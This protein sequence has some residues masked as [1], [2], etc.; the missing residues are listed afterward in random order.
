M[1][2]ELI[3]LLGTL[4]DLAHVYDCRP[5]DVSHQ[6]LLLEGSLLRQLSCYEIRL[7]QRGITVAFV[8]GH[9]DVDEAA[10]GGT[11][12]WQVARDHSIA[13]AAE[14]DH[15]ALLQPVEVLLRLPSVLFEA[16]TQVGT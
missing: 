4:S 7:L 13:Y 1:L 3:I 12:L 11:A 8:L 9:G 2:H 6:A 15:I 10:A 5:E 16:E 14:L